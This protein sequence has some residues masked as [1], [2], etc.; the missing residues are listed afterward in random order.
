[1]MGDAMNRAEF[2]S[3]LGDAGARP[4]VMGILNVTPDSFSDGGE[5]ATK[6]SA[7]E[8]ARRM[9]RE[10]ADLL[11]IGG[12][13]TRPGA[14]RVTAEEQIA[15][16]CPVIEAIRRESEIEIS[17]DTTLAA[18]AEAAVGAGA[19]IVNDIAAGREDPEILRFAGRRGLPVVLMHMLGE[20]GTM[21]NDPRYADVTR[22]VGEFLGERTRAAMA[23]GVAPEKI[24]LDP[25]IGF[26][27]TVE[28][29][30]TLLRDL[31]KVQQIA[32]EGV[33]EAGYKPAPRT[34]EGRN[35]GCQLLVG[36]SRKRFVGAV[37][38]ESNP[39]ER[40]HGSTASAAWAVL[41]GASIV[42][43]HDVRPTVQTLAMLRAIELGRLPE[44]G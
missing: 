29:N 26:G 44:N 3:W 1:M 25:G 28:H 27:K 30:L 10:G 12:E 21:Q 37:T 33:A 38:G 34:R 40:V 23:A 22:E 2:N 31:K 5:F 36:T 15:R 39:Q 11:D 32:C 8:Q 35:L 9:I 16:V 14:R 43:V 17:V 20:P 6:E 13:S 7:L 19:G 18:V 24:L 41:N 4:L 42:R